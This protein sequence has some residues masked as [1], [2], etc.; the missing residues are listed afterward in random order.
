MKRDVGSTE[1]RE[2]TFNTVPF[3]TFHWNL[4][5]VGTVM[6]QTP[7]HATSGT[8]G[9]PQD[10]PYGAGPLGC[11]AKGKED[12]LNT[13]TTGRQIPQR[14]ESEA[15]SSCIQMSPVLPEGRGRGD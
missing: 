6:T 12:T 10:S 3:G 4:G 11:A 14:V 1:L 2:H 15:P 7:S 8:A 13:Q 5:E 9:H